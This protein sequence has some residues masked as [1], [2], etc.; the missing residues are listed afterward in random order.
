MLCC[1]F[2]R[3]RRQLLTFSGVSQI[4]KFKKVAYI[5]Y[6][7]SMNI[8]LKMTKEEVIQTNREYMQ[9]YS[10]SVNQGWRQEFSDGGLTLPTRGL[11]CGFQ[12]TINDK[13]LRKNRFSPSDGGLA[14]SDG[15][16]RPPS[17][18]LAPPP[19]SM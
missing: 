14:C 19:V 16:L 9:V 6:C 1:Y 10:R 18:P 13:S 7:T 12:G 3:H 2:S 8:L 15:G 17:P 5:C 11:K 4:R